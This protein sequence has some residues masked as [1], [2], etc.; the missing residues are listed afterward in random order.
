MYAVDRCLP[1]PETRTL[2]PESGTRKPNIG[3][4]NPEPGALYHIPTPKYLKL[5]VYKT[6]VTKLA[7]ELL[8]QDQTTVF[9]IG[10]CLP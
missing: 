9:D 7:K 3:N 8:S 5:S 4:Q 1:S 6:S 10:R 2:N